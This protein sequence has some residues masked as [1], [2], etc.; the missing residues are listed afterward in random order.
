M[1]G[2]DRS[3]L[4][5]DAIRSCPNLPTLFLDR[6]EAEGDKP[7]LFRKDAGEWRSISWTEARRQATALAESLV[8]LGLGD[9]DRV[10]LLSENRPE[11]PISDIGIMMA[12]CVTVPA[13]TT[14]T[15]RDHQH[16][17]D[18]SG[19]RAII[20]SSAKLARVALPAV[21]RSGID[22][23][24]AM[25]P[26]RTGQ[27]G[28]LAVHDWAALTAGPDATA[29]V[30]A[31]MASVTREDLACVIYTSGTGG[32]PR[33][34]RQHHGMIL[35]N[36]HAAGTIV[37][38]DFGWGEEVF[39]SFLP[40]SHAYEHTGGQWLPI[41]LARK[42]TTARAWTSS[43]PISRRSARR[44][45]RWCRACSNCCAPACS[46]SWRPAGGCAPR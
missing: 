38:E 45:W 43:P 11:W 33:G 17:L 32:A 8:A 34:V 2:P 3:P 4:A 15:E 1:T 46:N 16:I 36:V 35:H 42:S 6:A 9:G 22:H 27:Q 25:E 21:L 41:G 40:L 30:R 26:L 13:Y 7:F 20:V 37:R 23:L 19:A 18:D 5:M 31:R 44:S 28:A 39:L 10:V 14:N 12:G 24:I 29:A